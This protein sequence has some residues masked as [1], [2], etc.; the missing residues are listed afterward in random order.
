[1]ARK[2]YVWFVAFASLFLSL[3]GTAW[4]H[5]SFTAEFDIFQPIEISGTVTKLEWINPHIAIY[6]DAKDPSGKT[7]NWKIESWGT[8]NCH[9]A[10]LTPQ[11]LTDG[12][13]VKMRGY[14]AKDGTKALAYLRNISFADGS[15]IELW[16]GGANGSPDQQKV[17]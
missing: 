11:K 12:T 5:H 16:V 13:F 8:G 14:R 10:G 15:G 1:M 4:A 2:I 9:R 3:S 6:V 7:V 17:Q